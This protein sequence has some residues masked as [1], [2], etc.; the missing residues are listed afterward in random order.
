MLK[1]SHVAEDF[2]QKFLDEDLIESNI[3]D[4]EKEIEIP[5]ERSD[6]MI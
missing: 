4:V 6:Y 5:T 2:I 1:N 3:I